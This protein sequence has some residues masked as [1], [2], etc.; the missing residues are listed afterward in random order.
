MIEY[1]KSAAFTAKNAPAL[2]IIL[3]W[4]VFLKINSLPQELAKSN[5]LSSISMIRTL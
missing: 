3:A 1:A 2:A 5:A 4:S